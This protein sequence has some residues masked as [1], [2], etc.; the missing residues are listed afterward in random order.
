MTDSP[1][2]VGTASSAAADRTR[3]PIIEIT[4]V[5]K[6]FAAGEQSVHALGPIDLT[7]EPGTFV[8]VSRPLRL[9]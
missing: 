6:T 9:R 2:A 7:I 4:G 1:P 3:V 8:S 5:G